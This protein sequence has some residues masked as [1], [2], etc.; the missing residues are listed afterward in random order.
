MPWWKVDLRVPRGHGKL[1]SNIARDSKGLLH[2][3]TIPTDYAASQFPIKVGECVNFCRS[4]ADEFGRRPARG[5]DTVIYFV[6]NCQFD[7]MIGLFTGSITGGSSSRGHR[8]CFIGAAHFKMARREWLPS[9]EAYAGKTVTE[10]RHQP[11]QEA[12]FRDT[13]CGIPADNPYTLGERSGKNYGAIAHELG[14][15]FGLQHAFARQEKDDR[16]RKGYLMGNG[17]RGMQGHFTPDVTDDF[18]YLSQL[19]A[20]HLI[21]HQLLTISAEAS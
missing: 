8:E 14:H 12:A 6:E 13:N 18:C 2:L 9:R 7:K 1:T 16:N 4:L 15:T 11:L 19:S 10:L 20:E 17:F 5:G 3:R 21:K